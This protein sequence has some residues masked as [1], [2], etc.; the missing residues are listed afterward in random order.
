MG[1]TGRPRGRQRMNILTFSTLYPHAARP[2]HGIFVETR[3]QQLVA[4][5]QL[6]STVMAPVP[7]FP[8]THSAFGEYATH[9]RAPRSEVRNGIEVLHPRFPVLPKIATAVTPFLLARA[10]VPTFQRLLARR[11]FDLIDAHYFYPD[12]VAAVMLGRRFKLP[13][14]VT[15]RGTDINLHAQYRLS[16][17]MIRWAA[18]HAAGVVA[19]S[20]AL[21][22]RLVALGVQP[23]RIEVLRNG[24]DLDLFRPLERERLRD[25]LG[26]KRKTLL[27]VGNLLAF[28]GHGIVIEALSLLPDC[29]LVIVG[30]GPDRA[31]FDALARERKLSDRVRF[32]GSISQ[33]ALRKYYAAADALVLASSRE[34]W[35]NVLLEA[36]ACGTPVIAT[37]V[38]GVS[39]IVTAGEAGLIVEART[40]AAVA[41][42]ARQLFAAPPDR[43]ATRRFAEQFGWEATTTGQLQLFRQVLSANNTLPSL[44]AAGAG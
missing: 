2:A 12:G 34:G 24:V 40:A 18:R 26:L 16:G 25:E 9:A 4:S 17:R 33:E 38:G 35:P 19:V 39:E 28:K 27:S 29:D 8:F 15:A 22:E 7:W 20:R 5:G 43:R 3:L 36:M 6:H 44:Q 30:E 42:A 32:A 14:V 10:V 21:K 41:M 11:R 1:T 37:D 31:A 13:V 23:D